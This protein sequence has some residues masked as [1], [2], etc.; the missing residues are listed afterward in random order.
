MEER[1][2]VREREKTLHKAEAEKV[3]KDGF[4]FP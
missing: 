4:V 2:D 3:D 1:Q